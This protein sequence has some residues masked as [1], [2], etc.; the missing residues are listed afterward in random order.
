MPDIKRRVDLHPLAFLLENQGGGPRR[1]IA[2]AS[3]IRA[4]SDWF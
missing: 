3:F 2:E 4:D 1:L